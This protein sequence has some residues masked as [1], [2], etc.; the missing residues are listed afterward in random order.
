MRVALA[1]GLALLCVAAP[2]GAETLV[3]SLST[4]RVAVTPNYAGAAV[5]AFGA[6]E[7]D[8]QSVPRGSSYDIVVTVLG[9]RE[10]LVVRQ[11]ERLGP[12]WINQEQESFPAMPAFIGVFASRPISEVTTEPLRRR[13]KVGVQ[14]IVDAPERGAIPAPF[15]EALLRLRRQERLFVE[16]DRG[17]TFLTPSI[18]RAPIPL[19]ATAP[20]GNYEVEIVLFADGV[21]LARTQTNFELVKTGIEARL[22]DFARDH[23]AL[24][25]LAT[26][27]IALLFGWLASVIFR[28]D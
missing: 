18:F 27:G 21:V 14:A 11:K 7:R 1:L 17:V 13:F 19:P 24:Y 15:R 23:G 2:A 9:P 22:A 16:N 10:P 3:S 28:R 25:G 4:S 6:I 8:G 20:P 26:A 5:V 12:I